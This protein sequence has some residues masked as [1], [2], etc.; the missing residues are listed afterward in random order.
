MENEKKDLE[1]DVA[2]EE[3]SNEQTAEYEPKNKYERVLYRVYKDETLSEILKISSCAIVVFTVYAFF[4]RLMA[5]VEENPL[6]IFWILLLTGIPFVAVSVLRKTINASRPY[7][8]FEFYKINPKDKKGQSFPSRHVFSSFI[9][10]VILMPYNV[11][12]GITMLVL[13]V[14][15]AAVRVLLGIH[16]IRDVAAGAAIGIACGIIALVVLQFV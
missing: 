12:L 3:L 16:F 9:I 15:L 6:E 11:L 8:F 4:M 2:T 13:G 7:E 5:L 14:V 10:S 1:Q